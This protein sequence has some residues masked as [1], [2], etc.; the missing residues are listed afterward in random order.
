MSKVFRKMSAM[1]LMV[2]MI[3]NIVPNMAF[4]DESRDTA[5]DDVPTVRVY[6]SISDDSE[7]IT[8]KDSDSRYV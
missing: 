8:G 7:F 3:T 5:G 4:A 1:I 2:M 6:L